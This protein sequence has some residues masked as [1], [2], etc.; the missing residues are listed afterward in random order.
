[1]E[2]GVPKETKDQE[3]RVGLSP[4][5]VRALTER[6]HGVFVETDAGTGA[7]FSNEDYVQAGASL[8]ATAVA[9]SQPLIVKVKEPL[10]P[11]YDYLQKGQLLFTYLHLAADRRLTEQLLESGVTAIAYE[12]VQSSS[13]TLPLLVLLDEFARLGRATTLAAAFSYVAGWNSWSHTR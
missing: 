4:S 11:E 10:Q 2:I 3:Y 1:M 12:T 9:W 8:V 7:G 6:G 13:H 5:S